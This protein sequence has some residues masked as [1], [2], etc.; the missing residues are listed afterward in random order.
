MAPPVHAHRAVHAR[1]SA[2]VEV[3]L[4]V[5]VHGNHVVRG[6]ISSAARIRSAARER[7]VDPGDDLGFDGGV[8]E[9]VP[10][11]TPQRVYRTAMGVAESC[12]FCPGSEAARLGDAH[13]EVEREADLSARM[14]DCRLRAGRAPRRRSQ[15]RSGRMCR[16][17]GGRP[18]CW[19]EEARTSSSG[20]AGT[21]GA[22]TGSVLVAGA[23]GAGG[24]M[25]S[26][27]GE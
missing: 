22:A 6:T 5:G 18:R 10:D 19:P 27:R 16:G 8:P 7:G 26:A 4:E 3:L 20:L 12:R 13:L 2:A 9:H 15:A 17:R 23:S 25:A 24:H 21:D 14:S 11:L 1:G